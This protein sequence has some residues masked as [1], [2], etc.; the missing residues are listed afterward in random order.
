MRR[1]LHLALASILLAA[2]ACAAEFPADAYTLEDCARLALRNNAELQTAEQGITIAKQRVMEAAFLFLPEVGVQASATRYSARYPFALRP[3]FRSILLFPSE[4]ENI[5][6]GQAYMSMPLYEGRRNINTLN[7]SQAALKQAQSKYDAAKLDIL[8]VI[9]KVFFQLLLAQE[10]SSA[11]ED[12]SQRAEGML[13]SVSGRW[14]RVEAE[15]LA[16][17]LRAAQTETRHSMD[18]A[19]LEF[20]KGLNKE[21]DAPVKVVGKLETTPVEINIQKALIWAT[22]LRPEL[23]SQTYKAQMDA[24]AVNLTLGRRYPTV[25]LGLDYELTD[26]SFPL[27]QNNWDATVGVKLPFAVDFWTQHTQKLAEQRQGEIARAELQDQVELEVR[28]AYMDMG[29]WQAEW[30]RREVELK[31]L[32]ALVDEAGRQSGSAPLEPLRA[33]ARLFKARQAYL[34]ALTEHIL[35]RARFERAV[36]RQLAAE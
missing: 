32:Q 13:K 6:S 18:V 23:K 2:P 10:V 35:A 20:L 11:A 15:A 33:Q 4:R 28:R 14:E 17:E 16:C 8:Y 12:A 9:K 29:Y 36:G 34:N 24:I 26:Q 27:K 25:A 7:M 3:N 30:P 5:Y 19:R 1:R 21:F 22:E 31:A